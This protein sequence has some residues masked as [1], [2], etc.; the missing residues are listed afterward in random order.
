MT[1]W[2]EHYLQAK[3]AMKQA[4][5][6]LALHRY[7]EG[8]MLLYKASNELTAAQASLQTVMDGATP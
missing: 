1:D 8:Q 7:A 2:S 3:K 4:E 6:S 5:N